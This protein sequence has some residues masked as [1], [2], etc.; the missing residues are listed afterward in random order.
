MH[1]MSSIFVVTF[2][3]LLAGCASKPQ[4]Q[5]GA[6]RL[7]YTFRMD[8]IQ[9]DHRSATNLLY[10]T[11][12]IKKAPKNLEYGDDGSFSHVS[13]TEL[14]NGGRIKFRSARFVDQPTT[15]HEWDDFVVECGMQAPLQNF[16]YVIQERNQLVRVRLGEN[17]AIVVQEHPDESIL[18][19]PRQE[20]AYIV[21]H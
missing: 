10:G 11:D 4:Y 2:L 8:G 7:M 21:C 13:P 3:A 17:Q 12:V 5:T 9:V 6:T 20:M 19:P 18:T 15:E 16:Q 14:S 1:F